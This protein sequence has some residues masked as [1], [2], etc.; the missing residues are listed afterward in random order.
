ML[1]FIVM[2]IVMY[3]R[4]VFQFKKKDMLLQISDLTPLGSRSTWQPKLDF[5]FSDFIEFK[6]SPNSDIY[7]CLYFNMKT[8]TLHGIMSSKSK[9]IERL[10]FR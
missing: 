4:I 8:D 1:M 5:C 9:N 6:Y 3:N 2:V 10:K 7:I